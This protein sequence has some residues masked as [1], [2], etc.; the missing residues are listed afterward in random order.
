MVGEARS[1]EGEEYEAAV[2]WDWLL[3]YQQEWQGPSQL[4]QSDAAVPRLY[5]EI[6]VIRVNPR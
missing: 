6:L 3:A 4:Q 5:V 2:K 1:G